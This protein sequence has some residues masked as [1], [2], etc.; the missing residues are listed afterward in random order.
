MSAVFAS[1]FRFPSPLRSALLHSFPFVGW[2]VRLS[3][4]DDDDTDLPNARVKRHGETR[5]P[6]RRQIV[7]ISVDRCAMLSIL[8]ERSLED[9]SLGVLARTETERRFGDWRF[10]I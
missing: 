10:K 6:R 9:G 7:I 1:S 8:N 4:D 2:L 3:D 5:E